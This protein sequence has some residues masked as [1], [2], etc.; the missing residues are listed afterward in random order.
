MNE[1]PAFPKPYQAEGIVTF[2]AKQRAVKRR[3]LFDEQCGICACGCGQN[4][5]WTVGQMDSATLE[6]RVINKAGCR[7]DD[8]PENLSVWRWDCNSLKGSRRV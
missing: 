8:R 7:K 1:I 5:T 6:H 2:N 4:M 3:Y